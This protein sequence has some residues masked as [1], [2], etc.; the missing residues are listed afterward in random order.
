MGTADADLIRVCVSRS[1][2]DMVDVKREFQ[3]LYGKTLMK[4]IKV[5]AVSLICLLS[6]VVQGDTSGVY[7]S[8]LL[9]LI[10]EHQF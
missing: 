3:T 6:H 8:L 1:E 9:A 4:M 10:G 7:E 5:T 2:I